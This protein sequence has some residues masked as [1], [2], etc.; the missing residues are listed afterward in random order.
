MERKDREKLVSLIEEKFGISMKGYP[1]DDLLYIW[2]VADFVK[3][4]LKEN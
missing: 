1:D 4:K 2:K 3:K